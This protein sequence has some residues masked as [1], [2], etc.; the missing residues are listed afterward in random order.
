MPHMPSDETQFRHYRLPKALATRLDALA[1]SNNRTPPAEIRLAVEKHLEA[2][3]KALKAG[4][5]LKQQ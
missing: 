5:R 2:N 4:P 1:E 3:R